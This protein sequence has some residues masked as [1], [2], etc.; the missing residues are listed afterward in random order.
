M[1]RTDL[2]RDLT[3]AR[4]LRLWPAAAVVFVRR[5]MACPGCAMAPFETPEEAA[6][7]YGQ[8]PEGLL[9]ELDEAVGPAP[10]TGRGTS[11][12]TR[13]RERGRKE[14]KPPMARSLKAPKVLLALALAT[15]ALAARPAAAHCDTVDGP[16]AVDARAALAGGDVGPVLKWI[17]ADA[18]AEIRAAFARALAV[19]ALSPAAAELA[20]T[21]F[22]ETLVRVHRA[23]EGAPY[24]GLKPAGAEVEPGIAAADKALATGS[25]D[26]LLKAMAA[27]VTDGVRE[28]FERTSAAREHAGH[29]VAAGRAYVAAYV[30]FI[31]YVERVHAAAV[32]PAPA[33]DGGAAAHAH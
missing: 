20:D 7:A 26:A 19:R 21:Y 17:H 22:L 28:R 3:V 30:D 23:G 10:G 6:A 2:T 25:A 14:R 16:V 5:G 15:G 4:L 12:V 11:A 1:R 29:N 13:P 27:H 9:A 33:H 24:T 8:E 32:G 31:H 18:E